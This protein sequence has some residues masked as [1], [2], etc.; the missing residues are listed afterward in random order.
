MFRGIVIAYCKWLL[1]I[2][3][4]RLSA[5]GD[6][7]TGLHV[8]S[9]LRARFGSAHIGWLVE[10]R[11]ARLLRGHPQ[12]DSLHVYERRGLWF[13]FWRL[14][15]LIW[16]LRRER[17]DVAL[18]LQGNLK[19]GFL[20]WLAGAKRRA[21]LA[22]PHSKEGNRLFIAERV[23]VTSRHRVDACHELID[24]VL[25]P[26]PR[27]PAVLS[28]Q[29][30]D[31]GSIVFHPGTSGFGSF[32]RWPAT[33]FAALGDRLARRLGA[34]VLLTAGPGEREQA[35]AV[36]AALQ[37]TARIADTPDVQTLINVLAGA[38]LVVAGDTGPAHLAAALGVPT[39]TLFGPKDPELLAPVGPRAT[40]VTAGV[41]CSPCMLRHC[42]DPV[43]MTTLS[44]DAVEA[45]ALALLGEDA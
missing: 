41:R 39:V 25:G 22:A 13:R 33:R 35:E 24:A 38:R 26:G 16:R 10:D 21:G 8:L 9:T 31:H 36:G 29:S 20:T 3:V 28:A 40:A 18:D 43:C 19:S 23:E 2:L 17:Y 44:V 5:L 4:V 27:A 6:V 45:Q 15:L 37:S 34:P 7:V 11:F 30:S 42:P 12:I 32:K 1:R 14:P